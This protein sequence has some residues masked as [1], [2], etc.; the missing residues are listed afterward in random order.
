MSG[1][2][3]FTDRTVGVGVYLLVTI[4]SSFLLSGTI[5][6]LADPVSSYVLLASLQIQLSLV[7]TAL[8]T[9]GR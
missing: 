3:F 7:V 2:R 4:V 9:L 1:I 6:R 5:G 8:A